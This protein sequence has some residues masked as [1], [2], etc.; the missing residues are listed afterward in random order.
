MAGLDFIPGIREA[1]EKFHEE[2][3]E[4]FAGVEPDICGMVE[5]VPLTP[6]IFIELSSAGNAFFNREKTEGIVTAVDVAVFLWRVSP[7]FERKDKER[8]QLFNQV[9]SLLPFV[10]AVKEIN[11]YII[12]SWSAMPQ[13][14]GAAGPSKSAGVWPSRIVDMFASEYGWREEYILNMPFRRLWQYANRILERR[15]ENYTH[16]VPEVLRLR[17]KWLEQANSQPN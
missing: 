8:R 14:P 11:E 9:I 2:V 13:W 6:Q 12:R 5:V 10:D 16:K 3:L 1:E 4:S 7:G 15:V 17:Q